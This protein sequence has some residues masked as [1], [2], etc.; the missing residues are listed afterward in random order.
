[1]INGKKVLAVTLARGGSK[2]VPKKNIYPILGKPLIAYTIEEVLKSS[3]ID[4][5]IVSTDDTEIATISEEYGAR[6]PFLR[7]SELAQDTTTS[8]DALL[9]AVTSYESL[10]NEQ[11]DYVV[12][13]MCTNPLKTVHDIDACISKLDSTQADSVVAVMRLFDHHPARIKKIEDDQIID[14][15]VPEIP[16]SRR[17]DLVP[18]AYIRNGS[19]YALTRQTILDKKSRKGNVSR[20]HI[21]PAERTVNI[22]EPS[23]LHLAEYY[24]K[25]KVKSNET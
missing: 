3:H 8:V 22:D 15:V 9:H 24:L 10:V 17:Q 16:E 19:I 6:I 4:S 11:F 20:P 2:S 14:F 13:I 18:H 7:P 1:M 5:F 21:M 12:E 23:D 25:Q